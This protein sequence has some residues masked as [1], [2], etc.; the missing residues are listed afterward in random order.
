VRI[1]VYAFDGMTMF[2]LATPLLVFGEVRRLGLA[3]DWQTSVWTQDG[4]GIRT[5]EGLRVE[6][7]GGPD[8]VQGAD[9][10]VLP[11]WPADLPPAGDGD[12]GVGAG[13]PR[14]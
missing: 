7:V 3:S 9:I 2:H 5:A 12:H 10:V 8:V 6:D 11:S 14:P 4:H 1:A 13:Q